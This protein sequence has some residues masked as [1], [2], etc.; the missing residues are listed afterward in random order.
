MGTRLSFNF[1]D[2]TIN[3]SDE[4]GR[5]IIPNIHK[6]LE[7]AL[8]ESPRVQYLTRLLPVLGPGLDID[9]SKQPI[10]T[11][12]T[13]A[14]GIADDIIDFFCHTLTAAVGQEKLDRAEEYLREMD[15]IE[16]Q[17][18][19]FGGVLPPEAFDPFVPP[20][21]IDASPW[22]TASWGEESQN[23]IWEGSDF[24]EKGLD[25]LVPRAQ[26]ETLPDVPVPEEQGE[27]DA[28]PEE[29]TSGETDKSPVRQEA[30]VTWDTLAKRL[31]ALYD[32]VDA[33]KLATIID[34]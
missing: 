24:L 29:E 25:G 22:M 11:D 12:Q 2:L 32:N 16:A 26:A 17:C 3:T 7:R 1:T 27:A 6:E 31:L 20:P 5:E 28:A 21:E 14:A 23:W 30:T 33:S 10:Y 9:V 4:L 13:T 15:I 18:K 34:H 8:R 19:F